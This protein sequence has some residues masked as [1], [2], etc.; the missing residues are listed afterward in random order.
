MQQIK[1]HHKHLNIARACWCFFVFL[2][3]ITIDGQHTQAQAISISPSRMFFTGAKSQELTQQVTLT[4][5][6]TTALSFKASLMDWARDSIGEKQYAQPGTNALSNAQWLEV[7][8]NVVEIPSGAKQQLT[9]TMHVPAGA[10]ADA[11][12]H[13]MLF[14]TQINEQGGSKANATHAS[15]G[16]IV[17][18]EFGIHI[19][20]TPPLTIKKD[21]DFLTFYYDGI[22]T[23]GTVQVRRVAVKVKN[24][25]DVMT[26]GFISFEVTNKSTGEEFKIP[27]KAISMLPNDEQVIYVDLPITLKGP[28]LLVALL[29]GGE[30]TNLKVAKKELDFIY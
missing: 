7:A 9:V 27:A 1:K 12:T 17:K 22:K 13:S 29:D 11:V 2:L 3:L 18:L 4:N 14:L 8:P 20:Y 5:T 16:V 10:S 6:G 26:D 28:Y 15:I 23:S 25:G 21:L 19:Y 30:E 24:Q